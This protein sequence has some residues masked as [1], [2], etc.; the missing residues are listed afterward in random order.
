MT[1][2]G[3]QLR[4][5]GHNVERV[6]GLDKITGAAQYIADIV[7]PGI[8]Q[9]RVLRSPY[10]HA[11]ILH[12]D[13]QRA[14]KLPGV[15]AVVTGEDTPKRRWGSFQ[16]DQYV[17]AVGK[18]RYVGDEIAAVAA[19]DEAT[20]EEAISLIEVDY[21][22]L[23][24]VFDPVEALEAGAPLIHEDKPGNVA[25]HFKIERGE[26]DAALARADLVLED[27]FESHMQWHAAIET[28]GSVAQFSPRGKLTI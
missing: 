18:V 13:T 17:L 6:D 9:G 10:P 12:V 7:L 4:V 20:A 22:E 8:L 28:I 14:S 19:V 15:R 27:W 16:Q 25:V 24:A 1:Q 11:R 2:S 23:P 3:Q 5:V 26:P 21:E